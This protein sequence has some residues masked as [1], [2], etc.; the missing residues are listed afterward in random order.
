MSASMSSSA[1]SV[2]SQKKAFIPATV[3]EILLL[4]TLVTKQCVRTV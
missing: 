1:L 2:S 4:R 3:L